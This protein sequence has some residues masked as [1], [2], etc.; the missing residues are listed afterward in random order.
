MKPIVS[1]VVCFIAGVALSALVINGSGKNSSSSDA[2][3]RSFIEK[4]PQV[5]VDSVQAWQK[6]QAEA[7]A[8]KSQN[9][10]KDHQDALLKAKHD[11]VINPKGTSTIVE[12]FD[13]DCPACKQQFQ[14]IADLLKRDNSIRVIFKEFPIFGPA[15]DANSRIGIAVATLAPEK[16]FTFHEKMMRFEGRANT[17]QAMKF[18]AEIGL[19]AATLKAETEKPYINQKIADNRDLGDKLGVQGTPAIIIGDEMIPHAVPAE[20]IA[21]RLADLKKKK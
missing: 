18:A 11:G 12:F 6:S 5:I 19:D 20:E 4:N 8:A 7:H 13:Y 15:S 14:A 17:E 16:Y 1:S 10:A 21:L 9:A 2:A 3:I